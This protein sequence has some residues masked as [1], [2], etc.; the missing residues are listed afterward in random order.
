MSVGL[1]WSHVLGDAFSSTEYI[2]IWAQVLAGH[3]QPYKSLSPPINQVQMKSQGQVSSPSLPA[4]QVNSVGD[5]WITPNNCKMATFFFEI[6]ATEMQTNLSGKIPSFIYISAVI[7]HCLGKIRQESD[8]DTVT[9]CKSHGNGYL[10]N[11]PIL[12][13]VKADFEVAKSQPLDL[14]DL[15]MDQNVNVTSRVGHEVGKN[16]VVADYVLYGAYPTF[17]DL[18][19]VNLYGLELNGLKP[20]FANYMIHGVGDA[21][22]IIVL[23]NSDGGRTLTVTVPENEV[24]SLKSEMGRK[25]NIII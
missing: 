4:K 5:Y 16:E 9:I 7:W 25:W 8:P 20:V 24:L 10:G 22:V 2:N 15:I 1:R 6:P 13:V 12:S 19:G 11:N 3:H 17:V 14:A 21:G 23:P 18:E